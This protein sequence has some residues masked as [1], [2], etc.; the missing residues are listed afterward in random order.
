MNG[1]AKQYN[2][3]NAQS[4]IT[5]L[6]AV[7]PYRLHRAFRRVLSTL[8]ASKPRLS[9]AATRGLEPKPGSWCGPKAQD[10]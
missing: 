4:P 7:L 5:V 9:S 10:G 2:Q 6:G 8:K 3:F 1:V